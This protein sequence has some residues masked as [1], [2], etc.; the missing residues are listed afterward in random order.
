VL[1]QDQDVDRFFSSVTGVIHE[2][3]HQVNAEPAD[4]PF[5]RAGSSSRAGAC[6]AEFLDAVQYVRHLERAIPD[7]RDS[8][9]Y[10]PPKGATN[11]SA[12]LPVSGC[13]KSRARSNLGPTV[14]TVG[15]IMETETAA[16]EK[17]NR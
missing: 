12:L 6:R 2:G 10:R 14:A 15:E 1:Y 16:I 8:L 11:S 17:V 3:F 7:S 9:Q 13:V 5:S 4:S